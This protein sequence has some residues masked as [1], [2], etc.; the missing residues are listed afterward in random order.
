MRITTWNVLH[1][2][3]AVNWSEA[4]IERFPDERA[5]I[6]AIADRIG[7]WLDGDVDA[8]CLQEVSGDLLARIRDA[9]GD[10]VQ[11][12]DHCFTRVPA[13]HDGRHAELDDPREH[14]VILVSGEDARFAGS[15]TFDTDP[16]KGYVGV[17]IG[18]LLL[19][20]THVSSKERGPA[21]LEALADV[22]KDAPRVV[23]AGDFNAPCELVSAHLGDGFVLSDVSEWTRILT[24]GRG[25]KTIDHVAV[26]GVELIS[27][28]VLDAGGVSDHQPVSAELE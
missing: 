25:G 26:R 24:D 15:S 2:V 7:S 8:V 23:I 11:I 21:Q 6:A 13:F 3:H 19:V 18:D 16:G 17:A 27:A 14:L 10:R 1:R 5:R 4:P 20:C 9:V 28:S 12:F 22:T